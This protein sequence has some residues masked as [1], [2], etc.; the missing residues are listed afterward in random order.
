MPTRACRSGSWSGGTSTRPR[1]FRTGN[2]E[3]GMSN[4]AHFASLGH[5]ITLAGSARPSDTLSSS[6]K[7]HF[8]TSSHP[9]LILYILPS[10]YLAGRL[11]QHER[12]SEPRSGE[13]PTAAQ[14]PISQFPV[15]CSLFCSELPRHRRCHL[16]HPVQYPIPLPACSSLPFCIRG[17]RN[18]FSSATQ[19]GFR[20]SCLS[21]S[22]IP[23]VIPPPVSTNTPGNTM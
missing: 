7:H 6:S 3:P 17:I 12:P 22:P 1:E 13:A 9:P 19:G 4:G 23:M 16:P 11:D 21:F 5:C 2:R 20:E 18:V 14:P 10:C 15:R 8:N